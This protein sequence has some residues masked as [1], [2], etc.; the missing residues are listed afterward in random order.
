MVL[1]HDDGAV[2]VAEDDLCPHVY[3]LVDEE[4]AALKHLL[5]DEH[6]AAR[7]CRHDEEHGEQVG[8][9]TRQGASASVMMVPSMNESTI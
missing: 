4:E 2:R 3:E 5:M 9:Q 8:R 7:L 1:P 6:G